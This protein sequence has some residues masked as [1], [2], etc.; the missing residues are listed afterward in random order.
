MTQ[1]EIHKFPRIQIPCCIFKPNA[2]V[3]ILLLGSYITHLDWWLFLD[4]RDIYSTNVRI[5]LFRTPIILHSASSEDM[6]HVYLW[7]QEIEWACWHMSIQEKEISCREYILWNGQKTMTSTRRV[8]E[9]EIPRLK[10]KTTTKAKIKRL[11]NYKVSELIIVFLERT[12]VKNIS[13][14]PASCEN[15]FTT[16]SFT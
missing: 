13:I 15:I 14:N 3:V 6:S 16:Q 7:Y 12:S 1:S 4:H 2:H 9:W 5:W 11:S 8:I 10:S